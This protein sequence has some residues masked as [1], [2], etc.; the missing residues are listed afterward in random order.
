MKTRK[1]FFGMAI[2]IIALVFTVSAG[3]KTGD[4]TPAQETIVCLGD[5]LTSG[6][7][8]T[9]IGRD[10]KNNAWPALLQKKVNIPVINAGVAGNTA[11]QGLARVK[12]DVL[13][14]NPRIV[15]I[16]LGGNDYR[17][18]IPL[19]TTKNNLQKIIDM[20]NDGKRKIYLTSF[21]PPIMSTKEQMEFRNMYETLA[22]SN[23]I[24][25]VSGIFDSLREVHWVKEKATRHPTAKGHELIADKY[26][27]ALKPYLEANNLLKEG[28][29]VVPNA[30]ITEHGVEEIPEWLKSE[31]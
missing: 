26:F 4:S 12:K 24:Q 22:S 3:G 19:A 28:Y 7:S 15:I 2:A 1:H 14:K 10:D 5:S 16:F 6:Y 25:L 17:Q 30:E 31:E 29:D 20:V 13:S 11:A 8:A 23:N 18:K 21:S 27:Y 9:V